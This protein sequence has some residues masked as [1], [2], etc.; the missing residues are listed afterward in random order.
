MSLVAAVRKDVADA[1]TAI[2]LTGVVE[3]ILPP[4]KELQDFTGREI[5]VW[6]DTRETRL[7]SRNCR[8]STLAVWVAVLEKLEPGTESTQLEAIQVVVDTLI[9]E[10]LGKRT[11]GTINGI[12]MAVEQPAV[13][14]PA[15]WYEHR[16]AATFLKLSIEV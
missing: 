10:M 11:G 13:V 8:T 9:D 4:I 12:C 5:H 15:H 16:I 3:S 7:E 14:S 6:V 1:L 2:P